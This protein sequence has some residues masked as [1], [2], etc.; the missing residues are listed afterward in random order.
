MVVVKIGVPA[1]KK[2]PVKILETVIQLIH[3]VPRLPIILNY[4]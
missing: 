3:Q 4:L 2:S 1:F